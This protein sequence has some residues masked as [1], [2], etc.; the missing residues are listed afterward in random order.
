MAQTV[1]QEPVRREGQ[2]PQDS[3]PSP[4]AP[5]GNA[6]Q[7]YGPPAYGPPA[8]GPPVQG[9]P[10]PAALYP[11]APLPAQNGFGVTGLVVG[12]V[13]LV[14]VWIPALNLLLGVI[15]TVFGAIGWRKA[16][17]ARRRTGVWRSRA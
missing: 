10:Y 11:G 5:P 1:P 9:Q 16:V 13:G 12:I 2:E 3:V 17:R 7:G 15:A 6:P 4:E 8:Y 14:L